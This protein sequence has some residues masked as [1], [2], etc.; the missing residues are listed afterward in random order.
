MK[1]NTNPGHFFVTFLLA[2]SVL[3]ALIGCVKPQETE[4][5]WQTLFN[6]TDLTGWQVKCLPADQDKV[7]WKVVNGTIECDS[8]G[9]KDHDYV[10]LMHDR[11]FDDFQLS[12][13]FRTSPASPGN[14]GVQIRSRY[15]TSEGAPGGGWLDGPQVDLHPPGSWRTGLIYDETRDTRAW[16]FPRLED[17]NISREDASI[18]DPV[19]FPGDQEPYWNRLVIRCVGTQ[20][21]TTLNDQL[22]SDYDG[23]GLLDDEGHAKY[24]VGMNGHIALQLHMRDELQ[25]WFRDIRIQDLSGKR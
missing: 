4:S 13:E 8:I 9:D 12:L 22:V 7:Y 3:G 14:S 24:R 21:T 11:E 17:W 20:I 1:T 15:D 16:I 6:G 19:F 2:T 5:E 18:P 10:W 25:I 23:A